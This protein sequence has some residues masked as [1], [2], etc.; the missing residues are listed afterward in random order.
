MTKKLLEI[1]PKYFGAVLG[2]FFI[3]VSQFFY[4]QIYVSG[5]AVLY[6][7]EEVAVAKNIDSVFQDKKEKVKIYVA[8]SKSII[9]ENTSNFEI[10]ETVKKDMVKDDTKKLIQNTSIP[11]ENIDESVQ[12]SEKETIEKVEF[13]NIPK[14]SFKDSDGKQWNYLVSSIHLKVESA[15]I[16]TIKSFYLSFDEIIVSKLIYKTKHSFQH[17]FLLALSVRPP[18]SIL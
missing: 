14:Q 17:R 11:K 16:R 6:I 18:P 8:N 3:L 13:V 15:V 10:I 1:F 5:N 4:S 9:A 12:V 7:D 2:L